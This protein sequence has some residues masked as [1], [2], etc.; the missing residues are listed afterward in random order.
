MPLEVACGSCQGRLVVETPGSVVACPHCGNHLTAPDFPIESVENKSGTAEA[1]DDATQIFP[2][3]ITE[4]ADED[5][6]ADDTQAMSV[7]IFD[8]ELSK[9]AAAEEPVATATDEPTADRA[10]VE[11]VL[12]VSGIT[13]DTLVAEEPAPGDDRDEA[14]P[15]EKTKPPSPR[16]QRDVVSRRSFLILL[17]YASAVTLACFWLFY[18]VINAP[19]HN[20]ERLPDPVP[21]KQTGRRDQAVMEWVAARNPMPAGHT[22]DLGDS[23]QFGHILVKPLRINR[24]ILEFEPPSPTVGPVLKLW[25]KFTN[26]SD[27]QKIAP[28]DRT[29]MLSRQFHDG[30]EYTNNYLFRNGQPGRLTLLHNN[31]L[32]GNRNWKGQATDGESGRVLKPGESF[33]TYLPSDTDGLDTLTGSLLWRVHLRKGYSASG[34]GVTTIFEVAFDSSQIKESRGTKPVTKKS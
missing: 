11:D 4:T 21:T 18:Q 30:K 24:E 1:E 22:L 2:G 19:L 28:L 6:V 26:V 34:L 5:L 23:R 3:P 27:D 12:P 9:D 14:A 7:S 25:L 13:D 20:L 16:E 8:D 17:S 31:P 33:E 29:L 32:L 15:G 10:V